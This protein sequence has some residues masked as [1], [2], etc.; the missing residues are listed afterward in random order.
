MQDTINIASIQMISGVSV[1]KNLDEAE[2]LIKEAAT[3]GAKI[4][5]LPEF[6]VRISDA[7]DNS[8]NAIIENLGNGA[9]QDRLATIARQNNIFLI[10]GSIPIRTENSNKCYNSSLIYDNTGKL[11]VNYNKIHLFKFENS[12]LKFDE[13]ITFAPGKKIITIDIEGFKFGLAICYDLRFPEMFRMMKDIDAIILPAAFLHH[14][15]QDH[16]EVLLRARAIENQCYVIASGQGGVHENGRHTFGHSMIIDPW[17]R[18]LSILESGAG[19]VMANLSKSTIRE[20]R[21][22]LPA[23]DNRVF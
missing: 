15:G 6:F 21:A 16:W 10:A 11:L 17:G 20:I 23:L 14:T 9:I 12:T 1:D 4:A 19:I 2:K 8:F 5:V 3:L 22:Q 7:R 18:I 13:G